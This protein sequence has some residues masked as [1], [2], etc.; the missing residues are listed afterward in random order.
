VGLAAEG[1]TVGMAGIIQKGW[2][3]T[4]VMADEVE[5]ALMV[6]AVIH[7]M[8]QEVFL[9][10]EEWTRIRHSLIMMFGML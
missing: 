6:G 5:L 3:E 10:A 9:Q 1:V 8:L 2:R 7:L 4:A